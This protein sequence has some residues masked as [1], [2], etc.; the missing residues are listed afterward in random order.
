[1]C[2]A[3]RLGDSSSR[4]AVPPPDAPSCAAPGGASVPPPPP[5]NTDDPREKHA[6]RTPPPAPAAPPGGPAD[7]ALHGPRRLVFGRS[8]VR[9]LRRVGLS[10]EH[11]WRR[12]SPLSAAPAPAGGSGIGLSL[13]RAGAPAPATGRVVDGSAPFA[14]PLRPHQHR[15]R[16]TAARASVGAAEGEA[17]QEGRREYDGEAQQLVAEAMVA[18]CDAMGQASSWSCAGL[19]ASSTVRATAPL[20]CS[21]FCVPDPCLPTGDS[22]PQLLRWAVFRC[23][24]P[25]YAVAMNYVCLASLV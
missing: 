8:R 17:R 6:A 7:P 2:S 10:P 19:L 4:I 1:V 23:A 9:S 3:R 22:T 11:S 24:C 15:N 21:A 16:R 13:A 14:S 25:S 5:T 20:S 18:F 12:S